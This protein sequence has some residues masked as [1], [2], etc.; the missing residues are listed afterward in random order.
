MHTCINVKDARA[1]FR[2]TVIRCENMPMNWNLIRQK[3]TNLIEGKGLTHN[4]LAELSGVPQPT[5]SRFMNE[6][7]EY[8]TLDNLAALGKALGVSVGQ[9]IGEEELAIDEKV[10]RVITAMQ[11]LPE[12]KKD[13]VVSTTDALTKSEPRK[14]KPE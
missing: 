5:I 6:S 11:T 13:V 2:R 10:R 1:H 7:T 4:G 8:M 12:Y 14:P 9:L 3:L